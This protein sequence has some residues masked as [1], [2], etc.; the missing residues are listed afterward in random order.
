[1]LGQGEVWEADTSFYYSKNVGH[2]VPLA[3]C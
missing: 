2:F 1:M 3:G